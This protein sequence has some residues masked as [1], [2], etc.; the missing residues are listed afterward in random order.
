[1]MIS[2]IDIIKKFIWNKIIDTKYGWH[3]YIQGEID[4]IDIDQLMTDRAEAYAEARSEA[5]DGCRNKRR[6]AGKF[7]EHVADRYQGHAGLGL[8]AVYPRHHRC[9]DGTQRLNVLH[10]LWPQPVA[11]ET[12][13]G[14][15]HARQSGHENADDGY[16]FRATQRDEYAARRRWRGHRH[17]DEIDRQKRCGV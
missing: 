16:A 14:H 8:S 7:Q 10:L 13:P 12:R 11:E 2:M 1:M 4:D 5:H 9:R 17:D 15:Y 6:G 3:D